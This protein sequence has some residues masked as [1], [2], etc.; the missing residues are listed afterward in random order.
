MARI[1]RIL[2]HRP[3]AAGPD[4]LDGGRFMP[5]NRRR[6]S[7]PGLRSFLAIADLWQ[8][9]EEQRRLVLGYPARS[10]Y[11]H[12][13]RQ[14][15][16]QESLTLDADVLTRISAVLGIHQALGV[17]FAHQGE[18]LAWLRGAHDAPVFGG[19][20]P[21][22]LVTSGSQDGLLLVRRFLDAA[23]GGLYM[24]PNRADQDFA[25]LGDEAI[26]WQ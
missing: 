22:A 9:N 24:A 10:T 3:V 8:L 20:A 11:H 2:S 21:L 25:P 15:R 6:L 26:V 7:G 19:Q 1:A 16:A 23:R 18:G 14:A 17:L 12:W 5:E 13:M 4:L